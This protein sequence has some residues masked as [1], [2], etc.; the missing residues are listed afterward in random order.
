[1][2][3]GVYCGKSIICRKK[4]QTVDELSQVLQPSQDIRLFDE[5]DFD[6][7]H[8]FRN[9]RLVASVNHVPMIMSF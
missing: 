2:E 8:H 4:K 9:T 1:M 6:S 5:T 7:F 3:E